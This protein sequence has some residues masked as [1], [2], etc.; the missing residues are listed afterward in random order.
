[1]PGDDCGLGVFLSCLAA[2]WAVKFQKR[3]PVQDDF[4]RMYPAVPAGG[5]VPGMPIPKC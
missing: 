2:G 3:M 4:L 5:N 1:M